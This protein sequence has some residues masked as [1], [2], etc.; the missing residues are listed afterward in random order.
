MINCLLFFPESKE[1]E[2]EMNQQKMETRREKRIRDREDRGGL[3]SAERQ[4]LMEKKKERLAKED[5]PPRGE[6]TTS[7]TGRTTRRSAANR[8]RIEDTVTK[9]KDASDD[10]SPEKC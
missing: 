8:S 2:K 4:L 5:D 1:L 6:T 9:L 10:D 3:T 7:T